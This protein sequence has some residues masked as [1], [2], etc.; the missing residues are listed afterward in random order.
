MLDAPKLQLINSQAPD[1]KQ[2]LWLRQSQCLLAKTLLPRQCLLAKVL[3][4][5]SFFFS[6]SVS[7]LYFFLSFPFHGR[8]LKILIACS[9]SW[10]HLLISGG[11][12]YVTYAFVLPN[13]AIAIK[14]EIMKKF[15]STSGLPIHT[16]HSSTHLICICWV[17]L[18][19]ARHSE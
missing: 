14:S 16:Q 2:Q 3:T 8:C 5:V 19:C 13:K 1:P 10:T 17:L 4:S 12:N 15:S 6:L 7:V 18:P 11:D 9:L